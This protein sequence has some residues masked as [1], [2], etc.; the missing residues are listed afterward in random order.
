LTPRNVEVVL[1]YVAKGNTSKL[2][3]DFSQEIQNTGSL[4]NGTNDFLRFSFKV[5]GV[6]ELIKRS[7]EIKQEKHRIDVNLPIYSV[8]NVPSYLQYGNMEIQALVCIAE[9]IGLAKIVEQYGERLFEENVR[10]YL[11]NKK[12]ISRKSVNADILSTCSDER[13]SEYFWF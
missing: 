8:W 13:E 5:W 2:S 10:T 4:Y 12:Y 6:D 11:G 7:Y 1:H 9:S 3:P